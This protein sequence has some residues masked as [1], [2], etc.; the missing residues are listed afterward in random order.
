MA[1]SV[2]VSMNLDRTMSVFADAYW[3][4]PAH[5][6]WT[7]SPTLTK[8]F[9][10]SKRCWSQTMP[11]RFTIAASARQLMSVNVSV[12]AYALDAARVARAEAATMRAAECMESPWTVRTCVSNVG[13][14]RY[15]DTHGAVEA[16]NPLLLGYAAT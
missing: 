13:T 12:V 10:W 16:S 3:V 11:P 2:G 5:C 7:E 14:K 4:T 8:K 15:K 6:A 1:T 9:C